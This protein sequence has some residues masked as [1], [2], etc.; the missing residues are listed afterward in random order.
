MC[1]VTFLCGSAQKYIVNSA[2][3]FLRQ[4]SR[5]SEHL[6]V[7]NTAKPEVVPQPT[8]RRAQ[9]SNAADNNT[10]YSCA[11]TTNRRCRQILNWSNVGP[12]R[13][14]ARRVARKSTAVV[15]LSVWRVI[16]DHQAALC[17]LARQ[18]IRTLWDTPKG[19][20]RR[21]RQMRKGR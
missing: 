17:L 7:V 9:Q 21:G 6:V 1:N 8:R 18:E 20:A 3:E 4:C 2:R 14:H 13:R 15:C 5:K 19:M 10:S 12:S 11:P 16:S